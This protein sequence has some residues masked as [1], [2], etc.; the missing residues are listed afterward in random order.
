M[1]SVDVNRQ[2]D[3]RQ[4]ELA[5]NIPSLVPGW[6]NRSGDTRP[7]WFG[8]FGA[9]YVVINRYGVFIVVR[10]YRPRVYNQLQLEPE[11]GFGI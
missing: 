3:R 11:E 10:D 9:G 6:N 5:R 1:G 2:P 7:A 4:Q 8:D